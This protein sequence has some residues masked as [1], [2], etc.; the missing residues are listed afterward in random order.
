MIINFESNVTVTG[1]FWSHS[2]GGDSGVCVPH[3]AIRCFQ[4]VDPD[5]VF[6]DRNRL[7][8]DC[9]TDCDQPIVKELEQ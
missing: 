9:H 6:N 7:C 3:Y 8:L 4:L 2:G 5:H 1:D